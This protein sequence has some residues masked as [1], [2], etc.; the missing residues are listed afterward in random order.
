M[1][2][3]GFPKSPHVKEQ[4]QEPARVIMVDVVLGEEPREFLAALEEQQ[5][6]KAT[7]KNM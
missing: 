1:A 6:V 4:H 3:A 5:S 2:T 7:N